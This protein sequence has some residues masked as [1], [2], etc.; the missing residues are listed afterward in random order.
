LFSDGDEVLRQLNK[1]HKGKHLLI[2][3]KVLYSDRVPLGQE[4]Y[5]FQYSVLS[6][7]KDHK[8]LVIQYD[9]RYIS[10]ASDASQDFPLHDENEETINNYQI[11]H[12]KENHELYNI[13]LGHVNK[14]LNDK[15]EE[16]CK[17]EEAKKTSRVHDLSDLLLMIQNKVKPSTILLGEFKSIGEL[18]PHIITLGPN[19]GGTSYKQQWKH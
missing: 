17:A 16:D 14:K 3:A 7:N 9:E 8:T 13:H 19:M 15:K 2:P 6:V 12:L 1:A 10:N 11:K 4:D 5:L 18:Q